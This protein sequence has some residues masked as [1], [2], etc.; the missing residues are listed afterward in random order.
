MNLCTI[1]EKQSKSNSVD[2]LEIY[3]GTSW[4]FEESE[5]IIH[6]EGAEKNNVPKSTI[7]DKSN[8]QNDISSHQNN[9]LVLARIAFVL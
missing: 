9:V 8:Q 2:I 7:V 6:T 1:Y 4:N 5:Y 3:K